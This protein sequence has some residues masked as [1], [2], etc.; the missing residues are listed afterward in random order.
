MTTWSEHGGKAECEG[1]RLP[2]KN[3]QFDANEPQLQVEETN[4]PRQVG[5]DSKYM[6]GPESKDEECKRY[7][8]TTA[9]LTIVANPLDTLA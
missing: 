4:L 8:S 9:E 2:C 6:A 1:I 3:R 7:C 5:L